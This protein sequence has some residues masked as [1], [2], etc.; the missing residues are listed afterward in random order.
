M[1]AG[2]GV[3]QQETQG[4]EREED[5]D[6]RATA[7][8]RPV[9]ATP[10]VPVPP[11]GRSVPTWSGATRSGATRSGATRSGPPGY[12]DA[13]ATLQLSEVADLVAM[14]AGVPAGIDPLRP[15]VG[16]RGPEDLAEVGPDPLLAGLRRPVTA[17]PVGVARPGLNR[18]RSPP[19]QLAGGVTVTVQLNEYGDA[20][21]PGNAS[22]WAVASSA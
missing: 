10:A 22:P 3:D 12:R 1:G 17:A 11:V 8:P 4:E 7:E 13:L 2:E 21:R 14:L 19:P 9:A 18:P 5:P 15:E 20:P 6:P 16:G